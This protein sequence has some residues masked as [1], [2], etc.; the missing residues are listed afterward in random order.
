MKEFYF[1]S[2][3]I[4][5]IFFCYGFFGWAYESTLWA[6]SEKHKFLN[7]GYL[8]GP[9][10]PIYGF[11]ALLDWTFLH[12]FSNSVLIFVMGA[13]ICC[14]IEYVT[15][16]FLEKVFHQRWWDYSNYPLNINGRISLLSALFFGAAGLFLVK[17]LHPFMFNLV[18]KIQ[19]PWI[20]I[21]SGILLL[22]FV[23]DIIVTT[24]GLKNYYEP[25]ADIYNR[26]VVTTTRPFEY[27]NEVFVPIDRASL[28]MLRKTKIRLRK[29]HKKIKKS[30]E[31]Q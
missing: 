16:W 7:R 17:F 31:V 24:I 21:V 29:V 1:K 15:H 20:Y 6:K 22:L 30:K 9:I 3:V 23:I 26:I 5:I 14:V 18:S 27:L 28:K 4:V 19:S 13:L 2:A 10:C 8:M 25:V 11:V 12:F